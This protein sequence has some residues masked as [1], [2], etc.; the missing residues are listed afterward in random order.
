MSKQDN[1]KPDLPPGFE[2]ILY[3]IFERGNTRWSIDEKWVY[4][5]LLVGA[6]ACIAL[7]Y[8]SRIDL[9]ECIPFAILCL[10]GIV[11]MVVTATKTRGSFGSPPNNH[12]EKQ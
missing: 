11:I 3:D 6:G 12:D 10:I 2:D 5:A 4:L 1:P 8:V 9:T 7:I